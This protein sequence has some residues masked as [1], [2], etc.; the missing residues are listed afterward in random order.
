MRLKRENHETTKGKE[1]Y[2]VQNVILPF[3]LGRTWT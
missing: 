3:P 2:S 1:N